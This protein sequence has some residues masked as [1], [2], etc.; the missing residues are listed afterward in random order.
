MQIAF[1]Y[2]LL[3]LAQGIIIPYLPRYFYALGFSGKQV[4]TILALLPLLAIFGPPCWGFVADRTGRP[5]RVLKLI[6]AGAALMFLPMLKVTSFW[7]VAAVFILYSLFAPAVQSLTD[8][9]AVSEAKR[10]GTHY[11][12]LRLWGSIGFIVSALGYPYLLEAGLSLNWTV[13]F[14]AGALGL[15]AL[16][17]HLVPSTA[18]RA[19][20]GTQAHATLRDAR[21]LLAQPALLAFLLAAMTHWTAMQCYYQLYALHLD[22]LG[23]PARF[24]GWG[25][26]LGVC[27]EITVMFTF[28]S[29][30]KRLPLFLL[31]CIAFLGSSLRWYLVSRLST[32]PALAAVQMFHGLSFGIFYV[33]SLG[34]LEQAVPERL[35]ATGW[36]LFTAV[37]FGCG[38]ILGNKLMGAAYDVAGAS[39][40]FQVSAMLELLAPLPLI[41]LWLRRR[42]APAVVS[43]Q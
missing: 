36:A 32:G 33:G 21:D 18:G 25:L 39:A 14:A 40:G 9:I 34:H 41:V 8:S 1:F 42:K 27:T 23:I 4:G 5:A 24:I 3:F 19:S 35:R 15:Y 17:S 13:V 30:L 11:G 7:A 20:S 2:F 28:R 16:A 6:S 26:T 31:L 43:S 29:L 12:R 37:V 38:G 10:L 22:K